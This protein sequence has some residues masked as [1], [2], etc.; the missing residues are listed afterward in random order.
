ML[1][2][3]LRQ[4][5]CSGRA[6][7]NFISPS[8]SDFLP[9]S[10]TPC[11]ILCCLRQRLPSLCKVAACL[12]SASR[13][14]PLNTRTSRYST[15]NPSGFRFSL[16]PTYQTHAIRLRGLQPVAAFQSTAPFFRS[17]R[18]TRLHTDR[19]LKSHLEPIDGENVHCED[20]PSSSPF[21]GQLRQL[22]PRFL[23]AMGCS[24]SSDALDNAK[25]VVVFEGAIPHARSAPRPNPLAPLEASPADKPLRNDDDLVIADAP[26][27]IHRD[28]R[29]DRTAND[30]DSLDEGDFGSGHGVEERS[31]RHVMP[32][33]A[34]NPVARQQRP[35]RRRERSVG[36]PVQREV[37]PLVE[38]RASLDS[39]AGCTNDTGGTNSANVTPRRGGKPRRQPGSPGGAPQSLPPA[40]F[41]NIDYMMQAVQDSVTG[42]NALRTSLTSDTGTTAATDWRRN[43]ETDSASEL[44]SHGTRS[45]ANSDIG[46][47]PRPPQ[48]MSPPRSSGL[49]QSPHVGTM[50]PVQYS[51][52]ISPS[53]AAF[54]NTATH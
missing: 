17:V 20:I 2:F 23:L 43:R 12:K 8:H 31:P 32:S 25:S 49:L 15:R 26:M 3:K 54:A 41:E 35:H 21:I 24:G 48:L 9:V 39:E 4:P 44:A 46:R 27:G 18:S 37:N 34:T 38:R 16:R 51:N 14:V 6:S 45:R 5:S 29:A 19:E 33:S 13:D 50:S 36:Q 52:T 1:L 40:L 11:L 28:D 53:A 7:T 47:P 30:I 22:L 42:K 10:T